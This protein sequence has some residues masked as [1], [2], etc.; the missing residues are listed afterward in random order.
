[1]LVDKFLKAGSKVRVYDPVAQHEAK[2]IL[3][4]KIEY[5]DNPYDALEGADCLLLVTEWKEF[6]IP[7][8]EK[9]HSLL[10]TPVIFDGRNIY[11][12]QELK[13]AGFD[14]FCIGT[15]HS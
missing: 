10:K 12:C 14:Y 9:M 3:G 8:L 15:I 13:E 4:D 1:M 7:D 2:R 11:D 6:R 5:I